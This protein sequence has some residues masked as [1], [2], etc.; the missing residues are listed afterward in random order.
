MLLTSDQSFNVAYYLNV[1][2]ATFYSTAQ[3]DSSIFLFLEFH[4]RFPQS[5][6]IGYVLQC[7]N[8]HSMELRFFLTIRNTAKIST[9][10]YT[11]PKLPWTEN[12]LLYYHDL[13]SHL[14]LT[15]IEIDSRDPLTTDFH[16][17][18]IFNKQMT[19]SQCYITNAKNIPRH[20]NLCQPSQLLATH[21]V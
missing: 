4:S 16:H 17:N 13:I 20:L 1:C 19:W 21:Q 5:N 3:H 8:I 12:W 10:C 15:C 18:V 6:W 2:G 7:Y 11:I 9:E 14:S